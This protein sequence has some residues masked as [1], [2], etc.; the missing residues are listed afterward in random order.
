MKGVKGDVGGGGQKGDTGMKGERG[1]NGEKGIA[2]EKGS[3]GDKGE[4]GSPGY[5]GE[6]GMT[7]G[8]GLR[9]V[10]GENGN[11]GEK[12]QKGEKGVQFE[13]PPECSNYDL[14]DEQWRKVSIVNDGSGLRCD[15]NE[16]SPGWKRFSDNIGGR[17]PE[18]CPDSVRRCGTLAPGWL[19]G[20]HPTVVGQKTA[21]QVCFYW[22][23]KGCCQLQ[24]SVEVT[25][26]GLYY[27]YNL[28]TP[29][30]CDLVYCGNA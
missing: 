12:G 1:V 27:V 13:F 4:L 18:S 20:T 7:G 24:A 3:M 22:L 14:L 29:P 23:Q 6:K 28:P 9:G 19:N 21:M 10:K 15:R 26:C 16:M 17:M 11:D 25:N 2:G 8:T 30:S 5:K